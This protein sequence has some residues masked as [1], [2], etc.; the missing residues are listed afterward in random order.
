MVKYLQSL[1]EKT[2]GGVTL[3]LALGW[4]GNVTMVF[5][6]MGWKVVD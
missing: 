2:G 5:K 6:K 1:N 3:K 4:Q